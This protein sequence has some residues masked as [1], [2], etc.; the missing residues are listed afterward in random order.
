MNEGDTGNR[1][2]PVTATMRY[3]SMTVEVDDDI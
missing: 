1:Q 3:W 2:Q